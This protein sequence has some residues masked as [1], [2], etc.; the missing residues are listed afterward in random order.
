M[1]QCN[2]NKR[3]VLVRGIQGLQMSRL[4][5]FYWLIKVQNVLRIMQPHYFFVV[6]SKAKKSTMCARAKQVAHLL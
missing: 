1:L 6:H 3:L 5:M 2:L 4:L